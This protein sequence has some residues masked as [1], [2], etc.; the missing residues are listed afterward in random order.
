MSPVKFKQ[1]KKKD[2]GLWHI[3]TDERLTNGSPPYPAG[4]ESW[5]TARDTDCDKEMSMCPAS[6]SLPMPYQTFPSTMGAFA[7]VA[8]TFK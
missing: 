4:T 2:A 6:V 8:L 7:Q 3:K 1:K 5:K